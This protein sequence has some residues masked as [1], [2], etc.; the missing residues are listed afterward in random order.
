M[1]IT[2]FILLFTLYLLI[3]KPEWA[4]VLFFTL[5]IAAVNFE[6]S[7]GGRFR[8]L[9]AFLL[10]I[11]SVTDRRLTLS[12]FLKHPGYRLMMLFFGYILFL[13]WGMQSMH[14]EV[15]RLLLLSVV[16][17]YLAFYAYQIKG[18]PD[19]LEMAIVLSGLICFADLWY[20]YKIIGQF[21]VQRLYFLLFPNSLSLEEANNTNHNFYGFI[22]GIG[23]VLL[24]ARFIGGGGAFGKWSIV[25]LPL[26]FLG[27]LMSTSRSALLG[28][29][30]STMFVW[31]KG[32]KDPETRPRVMA[33]IGLTGVA[34][35]GILV[36]FIA[37]QTFLELDNG[38]ISTIT[39]RLVEEPIA[40]IR[41]QFGYSY[42][43]QDLDA[44]DWRKESASLAL[45]AYSRLPLNEQL[46]GV[47]IGGY[48]QRDLGKN[49]LNPHNGILYILV[50]AGLI[51]W[52][53][54]AFM[55]RMALQAGK[56]ALLFPMMLVL[57][58]ILFYSLGQNEELISATAMSFVSTLFA[59]LIK[60][61]D[62]KKEF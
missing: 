29:V 62:E 7:V 42:N 37:L 6:L 51:G 22:C 49:G 20:T 46:T 43:V 25:F 35:G 21:P 55:F 11:R 15:F 40:V 26:L 58:F 30:V 1:L 3:R 12:L 17:A 2:S 52:M 57:V 14:P 24:F 18:S 59:G 27:V 36:V 4:L 33:S 60:R 16:T 39:M 38:F 44:M 56:K 19:I 47:G 31:Y 34:I 28:L 9:L 8:P 5:T 41:K 50:E 32:A 48:L 13:S 54:Y 61:H 53:I 10:V 45:D 23:F